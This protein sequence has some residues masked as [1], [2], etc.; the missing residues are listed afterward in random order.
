MKGCEEIN[1]EKIAKEAILK[2]ASEDIAKNR[3]QLEA[4]A[5]EDSICGV[6]SRQRLHFLLRFSMCLSNPLEVKSVIN[7]KYIINIISCYCK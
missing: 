2:V 1:H 4:K 3:R 5:F 7:P 6:L